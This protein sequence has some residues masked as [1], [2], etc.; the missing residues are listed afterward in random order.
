M[1]MFWKSKPAPAAAAQPASAEGPAIVF[2]PHPDVQVRELR[3]EG[4][5]LTITLAGQIRYPAVGGLQRYLREQLE[6]SRPRSLVLDFGGIHFMDSQGLALLI[7]LYRLCAPSQCLLAVQRP[8]D[9]LRRLLEQ[10]HLTAFV[11]IV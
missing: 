11:R 5:E 3:L 9:H 6:R 1:L 2:S 7:A 4:G 10:T 8:S